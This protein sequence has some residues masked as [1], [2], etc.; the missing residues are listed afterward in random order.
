MWLT[1][2]ELVVAKAEPALDPF[3]FCVNVNGAIFGV[4]VGF[5]AVVHAV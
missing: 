4:V 2:L 5:V 1:S 3:L